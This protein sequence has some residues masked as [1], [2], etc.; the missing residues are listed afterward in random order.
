MSIAIVYLVAGLSSRF[1]GKI[2][3]FAR[4]GPNNETLIEYS[5]N[6]ALK[7][8]FDKIIFIVGNKT[9][10]G[11]REMF[12]NNYKGI[13]VY[14]AYQEY[15]ES[16]RDR[17]W[18][19]NDAL[20]CAE[21][22]LDC[23]FVVCNGDD[24]Y[25]EEAFQKLVNYSKENQTCATIGYKLGEV[26]SENGSVNRGIFEFDEKNNLIS[27]NENFG[28]TKNNLYEKNL[29]KDS[30]CSM[31]IFLLNPK[32]VGALREKLDLFKNK[33]KF[34]RK[35]ECLLPGELTRLISDNHLKIKV[36]ETNERCIGVTNPSDEESVRREL[37]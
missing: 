2:K 1:G 4:V 24:I 12:G 9:E 3:Q 29:S 27:I 19:T 32:V 30:A 13:S 20:C 14:Y 34:D 8:G 26:L 28:I 36:L 10:Q 16:Q 33:N 17:P 25:G 18:G 6:Q 15:D 11:F 7:A 22:L 21:K 31:N 37:R 35:V 5:L 23:P